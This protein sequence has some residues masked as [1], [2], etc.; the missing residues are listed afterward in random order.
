MSCHTSFL[1][2]TFPRN[3]NLY[4]FRILHWNCRGAPGKLPEIQHFS[5]DYDAICLQETLL[6]PNKDFRING[7]RSFR[8]DVTHPSI[9]GICILVRNNLKISSVDLSAFHHLSIEILGVEITFNSYTLLLISVYRH[10]NKSTPSFVF[11]N[12]L[13]LHNKYKYLIIMGDFNAHHPLWGAN[14][15]DS[16]GN[17]IS[18]A[19][20]NHGIRLLNDSSPTFLY[21]SFGSYSTVDLAMASSSVAPICESST[22]PDPMGSDHF[23]LSVAI[24]DKVHASNFFSYR[25]K[26]TDKELS[27]LYLRL[28]SDSSLL[29]SCIFT[30]LSVDHERFINNIKTHIAAIASHPIDPVSKLAKQRRNSAPWWNDICDEAVNARKAALDT[31]KKG[32]TMDNFIM[33]K[34]SIAQS[35]KTLTKQKALGWH[36]FCSSFNFKTPTSKLWNLIRSFK[37]RKFKK[38]IL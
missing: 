4:N 17:F 19:I 33:Y 12:V 10:P 9:R 37:K 34:K 3:N 38:R 16:A 5:K 36:K 8:I 24:L 14:K 23:P 6:Y 35:R 27:H 21:S 32:I 13:S 1:Q 26:L 28:D 25:I 18:R 15:S 20:E 31:F 30:N 22:L 29:H 11:S 2:I 7:F